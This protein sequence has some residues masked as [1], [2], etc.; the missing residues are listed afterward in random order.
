MD[1]KNEKDL[2][3]AL[4]E[5]QK[6]V[7]GEL[8]LVCEDGKWFAADYREELNY[9]LPTEIAPYNTP[10]IT[11]ETASK[12]NIDIIKCCNECGIYFVG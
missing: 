4:N 6:Y 8:E 10:L 5:A 11:E 12:N 9:S 2:I 3:T 1:I 7:K